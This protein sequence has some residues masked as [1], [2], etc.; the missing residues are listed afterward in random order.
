MYKGCGFCVHCL[1]VVTHGKEKTHSGDCS[2]RERGVYNH[3]INKLHPKIWADCHLS[4]DV[5]FASWLAFF[6][7]NP[8]KQKP[9][10]IW[11]DP[12]L[13]LRLLHS[14][15]IVTCLL[16]RCRH[17]RWLA[18][19]SQEGRPQ[20]YW[21]GYSWVNGGACLLCLRAQQLIWWNTKRIKRQKQR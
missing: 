16:P 20:H 3:I 17:E 14:V 5:W 1:F 10:W 4:S 9:S 19:V 7:R 13:I 11:F 18:V 6:L 15:S 21:H 8:T 2:D 12:V